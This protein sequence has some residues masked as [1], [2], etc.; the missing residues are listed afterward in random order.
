MLRLQIGMLGR[1]QVDET[2]PVP[3]YRQLYEQIASMIR[4]GVLPHGD[5]IPPTRELASQIGLN[6]TT[7]SA[8]YGL[9]EEEGLIR[10]HVGRGSFV[11][12]EGP[13][14]RSEPDDRISFE[15]SRPDAS[16][17][18]L[19]QFRETCREVIGSDEAA[20]ILQL[21]S[22]AGYA[23]LRRYLLDQARDE[24][25][26]HPTDDAI[27]TSGCQQALDLIQRVL[28]P[29]GSTV[30][31]EDPVYH[32]LRNVF[33]RAGVRLIGV[34][35]T[36]DGVD[37]DQ[38]ARVCAAERPKVVILTPDY[39]NPSGVSMPLKARMTVA[40]MSRDLQI[41]LVENGIY[42]DL[43]YHGDALPP[44]KKL[45][46]GGNTVLIRSFSKVSFPGLRVGWMIGPA[47]LMGALAEARQW[48]DLHTDHLSQAILLRFA[49]SGRLDKHLERMRAAGRARLHAVLAA[50]DKHLPAG[51]EFTRPTGGMNLWVR[52]PRGLDAS[53][54]LPRAQ[55]L[56]VSYV[57]GR[58][59]AVTH[60]DAETLRLSFGGIPPERIEA[61]LEILGRLFREELEHAG[62]GTRREPA[63][64]VV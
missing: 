61:G 52:L 42:R 34:R 40:A 27:V 57:P 4:R 6:R 7:V 2:S 19:A 46:M 50:C 5:R 25:L 37:V 56:G 58:Q 60:R 3:L 9:L 49:E 41:T 17:F 12:Y 13:V 24:A 23:P 47:K 45:D 33:E 48:C 26:L 15:S 35:L 44:L 43:R 39:Q 55:R 11:H 31:V 21:G 18:P 16:Q 1:V 22:P 28:A 8:A 29:A 32:G 59:F 54:L 30:V 20:A 38:L 53:E 51:S 10:G 62:R 14:D 36:D 64:A 63:P